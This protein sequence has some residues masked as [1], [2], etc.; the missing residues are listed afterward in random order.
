[1]SAQEELTEADKSAVDNVQQPENGFSSRVTGGSIVGATGGKKKKLAGAAATAAIVIILCLSL[2]L[3]LGGNYYIDAIQTRF[4]EVTDTQYADAV[5]SKELVFQKALKEGKIPINTFNRLKEEEVI[6]GYLDGETFVESN[7][8]PVIEEKEPPEEDKLGPLSVKMGDKIISADDFYYEINHNIKLYGAFTKSTYGR[9]A[10]Y[11]DDKAQQVFEKV[12][13]AGSNSVATTRN[14]FTQDEDF[15]TTMNKLMG[16]ENPIGFDDQT[17][18]YMPT[19]HPSGAPE[20]API[21]NNSGW[22]KVTDQFSCSGTSVSKI[23]TW[24]VAKYHA[25]CEP[26]G[27]VDA[28][29]M[30]VCVPV[31]VFDGYSYSYGDYGCNGENT[32]SYIKAMSQANMSKDNDIQTIKNTTDSL[33]AADTLST[34]QKSMRLY[35]GFMEAIS[36]TKAGYGSYNSETD[37]IMAAFSTFGA[38]TGG[39]HVNDVMN[40]MFEVRNSIVVDVTTGEEKL[41]TG[42][43]VEAPS[44]YAI[45]TGEKV[46]L[47][48]VA[49]FSSDRILK[50]VQNNSPEYAVDDETMLRT[51]TNKKNANE[52]T[53]GRYTP[54]PGTTRKK[55]NGEEVPAEFRD[56]T[57][58]GSKIV[59]VQGSNYN[60]GNYS[61]EDIGLIKRTVQNSLYNTFSETNGIYAGQV[62][63]DGALNL[64]AEFSKASGGAPGDGEAV[65]SYLKLTSDVLA[66]DAEVDRMNRSPLD[67]TSKNTFLGSLVYKFA[68]SSL[69]SG[70][71]LNKIASFSRITNKA[72][73]SILPAAFAE[74]ESDSYLS[75]FGDCDTLGSIGA[76]GSPTCTMIATFDVT[77]YTVPREVASTEPYVTD[78]GKNDLSIYESSEFQAFIED[79][80]TCDVNNK[81]CEINDKEQCKKIFGECNDDKV[82]L[83]KY[84]TFNENR[85]TPVGLTDAS[86][87]ENKKQWESMNQ[88]WLKRVW[89][90]VTSLFG[91]IGDIDDGDVPDEATGKE[92]VY[93]ASNGVASAGDED[94]M[95][96]KYK[97][98][99]RYISLAR[100]AEAMRQ[101]DGDETAYVF[102]GFG[103]GD[104][105]ARYMDKLN[106]TDIASK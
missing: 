33:K 92:F 1:M 77:T 39:S 67:I 79:N 89:A 14:N 36:R 11:Y 98:A 84:V 66:M 43:M 12:G 73:A 18:H 80:V 87:V 88:G 29:G 95:W 22:E 68:V 10:Y 61:D 76:V 28:E 85:N 106:Q 15:E 104:P 101:Y 26:T 25:E 99:Q 75:T 96:N 72:V 55:D 23:A 46:D 78:I 38:T 8:G 17:W 53:I 91:L 3:F 19:Y 47:K 9:A 13:I 40:A 4:V 24:R 50:T 94:N 82:I 70:S 69:R 16:D 31:C 81:N 27:L 52:S 74:E 90:S 48:E 20:C 60:H 42:S 56:Y 83:A 59:E 102:D 54:T 41:L 44:V 6:I 49:D 97:Y 105:V 37:K 63:A 65:L 64:G 35:S 32:E 58:D 34:K 45:L 86:L 57:P 51:A 100:A 5:Q 2:F 71:F 103:T 62:L 93:K 21:L 7:V 30:P